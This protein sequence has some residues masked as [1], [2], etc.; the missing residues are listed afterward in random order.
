[1]RRQLAVAFVFVLVLALG[2]IV[3]G[4]A[5][6]ATTINSSSANATIAKAAAYVYKINESTYLIFQPNLTTAYKYLDKA[7]K[8]LNESPYLAA[9]YAQYAVVSANRAYNKLNAY[10]DASAVV[11]LIIT[12]AI[13]AA[14]YHVMKRPNAKREKRGR[15][16]NAAR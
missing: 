1:M 13:A 6:N 16:R 9:T 4:Q 7:R 15:A 11:M 14:L 12:A 8:A 2:R 3:R 5:L 10:R